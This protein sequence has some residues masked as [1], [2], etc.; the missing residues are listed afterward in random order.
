ME[1][2]SSFERWMEAMYMMSF[3]FSW[4]ATIGEA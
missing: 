2:T 4:V 1:S 3:F